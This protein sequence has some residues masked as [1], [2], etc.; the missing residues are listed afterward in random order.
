MEKRYRIII[1]LLIIFGVISMI[2]GAAFAYFFTSASNNNIYG[3]SYNFDASLT[4][5]SL[6]NGNLIPLKSSLIDRTMKSNNKCIDLNN[7]DICNYYQVTITNNGS[8][9]TLSGYIKTG[10]TTNKYTTDHLHF[11]LYDTNYD[12][13]SGEGVISPTVNSLNYFKT[14]TGTN[15]LNLTLPNG[16]RTYYLTLWLNDPD[17]SNQLEDVNKKFVGSLEFIG[18]NGGNISASFES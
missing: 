13:V 3:N 8:T 18:S 2:I 1:I 15:N 12:P 14:T 11:K 6:K 16:T 10:D 4:V 17:D 9:E 5:T 7:N